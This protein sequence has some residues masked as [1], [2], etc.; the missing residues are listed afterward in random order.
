MST[1]TI[2][3]GII[4]LTTAIR[5]LQSQ[6]NIPAH[7][8]AERLPGDPIHPEYASTCA[9]A[10]HLS[11]AADGDERQSRWDRRSKF[12][13]FPVVRFLRNVTIQITN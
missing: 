12:G 11:F 7:I 9:G 2:G 3:S 13:R 8:I 5:L 4:G 6:P 10:H 1:I